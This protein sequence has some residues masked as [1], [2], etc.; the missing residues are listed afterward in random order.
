MKATLVI[1]LTLIA[2]TAYGQDSVYLSGKIK[3]ATSGK[4]SITHYPDYLTMKRQTIS[5]ALLDEDGS[6]QTSFEWKE[7]GFASFGYGR[8]TTTL[9]LTPG[10]KLELSLDPEEF[11]ETIEYKGQESTYSNYYAKKYLH[12]EKAVNR[13]YKLAKEP[14]ELFFIFTD[15]LEDQYYSFLVEHFKKIGKEDEVTNFI[16]FEQN[17]IYYNMAFQKLDYPSYNA[18]L[19]KLE[20]EPELDT[21][22][23]GFLEGIPARTMDMPMTVEYFRFL[24]KHIYH[25]VKQDK[26]E[27]EKISGMNKY[28]LAHGKIMEGYKGE[29]REL[30]LGSNMM[31]MIQKQGDKVDEIGLL[32]YKYKDVATNKEHIEI[33]NQAYADA[34]SL[35]P[36]KMAPVFTATNMQ[37]KKVSL[38]DFR[39]KV[40]YLDVWATWCGPCVRE[41]PYAKQLEKEMHKED[42]VFLAVSVDKKREPW[43]KMVVKRE[44][45]GVQLYAGKDFQS[46]VIQ[47]YKIKGIPHYVIID[48]EGRIVKNNAPRPSE[49]VKEQLQ[50]LLSSE[51]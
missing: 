10:D 38:T 12:F 25:Q 51:R 2:T 40:I 29:L 49:G 19:N 41:I 39:G 42:I 31:R 37:G 22:F 1:L 46:D 24:K 4:V 5:E 3:N 48:H 33:I 6:F 36:G 34:I 16:T 8:E 14:A 15:S 45:S 9:Y 44:L 17:N 11:D 47:N 28:V 35:S 18:Y 30:L 32:L 50:T 7:K 23:F 26:I 20:E 43:E 21:R 27:Y 13:M